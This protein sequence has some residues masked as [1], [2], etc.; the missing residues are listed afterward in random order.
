MG[1]FQIDFVGT[2][3]KDACQNRRITSSRTWL[4]VGEIM[5][6]SVSTLAPDATVVEAAQTMAAASVS[7]GVV[8]DN[9]QVVGIFSETDL[10]KRVAHRDADFKRRPVAEIMSSP[11]ET[12][13]PGFSVLDAATLMQEM[14]IKR[15]PV[16]ESG[17]LVGII[18][19]TDVVRTMASYSVWKDVAEIMSTDVV[20]IQPGASVAE[21]AEIMTSG[22]VSCAVAVDGDRAVGVL[23]KRD[24]LS[25][26][27]ARHR[28]PWQTAV[29]D[30]MSS[31][32]ITVRSDHSIC[33][34]SRTM[35]AR[36]IRRLVVADDGRLHGV[37]S[38]TDVF[39]AIREKLQEEEDDNLRM[40]EESNTCIYTT[41][42]DGKTTYVN[43]AFLRL[44]EVSDV[45]EFIGQPFLPERFWFEPDERSRVLAEIREGNVEVN[46][47]TLKTSQGRR[48]YVTLFSAFTRDFRGGI[49]GSQGVLHDVTERRQLLAL[50]EAANKAKSEF[51]ANVSHEIRTPMMAILGY[52][53]ILRA[54]GDLSKAP[55]KRIKALDVITRNGKYLLDIIDQVL[56]LAKIEAG[57]LEIDKI[58]CSPAQIVGDVVSLMEVRAEEKGIG[59]AIE[60]EGRIPEWIHS[61]PARLKQILINLVANAVKFTETGRVRVVARLSG[62][63]EEAPQMEFEVIDTGIGLTEHQQR[64]IFEAFAQ[65]DASATRKYGGSGL[66]LAIAKRLAESLGGDIVVRSTSGKGSAF[67]LK[68]A[69]GSLKR[70]SMLTN[71]G[72]AACQAGPAVMPPP[73]A[74][75]RLDCRVLLVEDGVDNQRIM[76]IFLKKAGARVTIAEHGQAA[77]DAV[78]K[79]EQ[80]RLP[81]DVILMDMQMP[82]LDGY[83]ATRRLRSEGY[84]QPIIALTAH[85]M[86]EDRQKCLDAGCDDY[87]SK[88][89][90]RATLVSL[91]A[92]HVERRTLETEADSEAKRLTHDSAKA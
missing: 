67:L 52:T 47:L 90:N 80:E 91:V 86:T 22:E 64:D 33:S 40:L 54:Q 61:D 51:L 82:V 66:G 24:M 20:R 37:V 17:R 13:P 10:L 27:V 42:G 25:K 44:F 1:T 14:R 87:L 21:A 19:Q 81:F 59:L 5:S 55:P 23:T 34:A 92:L 11:I 72:D 28:D 78:R 15:L 89:L 45:A 4:T 79:A 83:E 50:A 41:D 69:T 3:M 32:A 26:V 39:H 85:A 88:P 46:D 12:V 2:K 58:R 16:V 76:S 6:R 57:K 77:L 62:L 70:V 38:Q 31:P 29:R 35:D 73:Q 74:D 68:V 43:P 53:E 18:T 9:G 63:G 65:V 49:D 71:P 75:A 8:V 84:V 7:C 56:D 36:G 48:I 30:V 60:Y